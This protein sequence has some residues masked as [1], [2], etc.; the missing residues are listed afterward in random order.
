MDILNK[1]PN[2]LADIVRQYRGI[3][4]IAYAVIRK[5]YEH[6]FK[7][8]CLYEMFVHYNYVYPRCYCNN[9]PSNGVNKLYKRKD[10]DECFK[11]E[12]TFIYT[13]NDFVECITDNPQY[14]KIMYYPELLPDPELGD[15]YYNDDTYDDYPYYYEDSD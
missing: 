14:Q 9:C 5:Y 6:L 15:E 1:L 3:N 7:K 8:K 10:C 12:C 4:P 11:F 13:P 2:E